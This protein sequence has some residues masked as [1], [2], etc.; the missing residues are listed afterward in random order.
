M[1]ILIAIITTLPLL[2]V[3]STASAK[4]DPDGRWG[5]VKPTPRGWIVEPNP[6]GYGLRASPRGYAKRTIVRPTPRG[7]GSPPG[8]S[9]F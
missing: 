3:G 8:T 6:K 5:G 2:A 9:R 1:K 4:G 7:F